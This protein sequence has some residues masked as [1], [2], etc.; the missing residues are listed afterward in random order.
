MCS[1]SWSLINHFT[2]KSNRC[3]QPRC[4]LLQGQH[5]VFLHRCGRSSFSLFLSGIRLMSEQKLLSCHRKKGWEALGLTRVGDLLQI[6]SKR[7]TLHW[8]KNVVFFPKVQTNNLVS[9]SRGYAFKERQSYCCLN[10]I[11]SFV[12]FFGFCF[13]FFYFK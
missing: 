1:K 10:V 9:C 2:T 4:H 11:F 6:L 8:K 12:C 7:C 13:V 5:T 3:L